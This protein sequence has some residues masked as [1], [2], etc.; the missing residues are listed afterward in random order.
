MLE[1]SPDCPAEN[2]AQVEG[3]PYS[4]GFCSP[5]GKFFEEIFNN[6]SQSLCYPLYVVLM[7]RV[8]SCLSIYFKNSNSTFKVTG[9]YAHAR[10]IMLQLWQQ[11]GH[12]CSPP[13]L[14]RPMRGY[15]D[16]RGVGIGGCLRPPAWRNIAMGSG[17]PRAL[18]GRHGCGGRSGVIRSRRIADTRGRI[19]R[20]LLLV[21]GLAPLLLMR[22]AHVVVVHCHRQCLQRTDA[23]SW[24]PLECHS[25]ASLKGFLL[26]MMHFVCKEMWLDSKPE[27]EIKCMQA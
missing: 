2:V 7:L 26:C 11:R 18:L 19:G 24:L 22:N 17:R 10:R 8:K 14:Q 15:A 16:G 25:L 3:Q 23:L 12:A 4:L 13:G 1:E 21:R 9:A 6:A 5:P 27:V 20:H